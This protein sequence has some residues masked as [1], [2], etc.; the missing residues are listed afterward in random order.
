MECSDRRNESSSER[1]VDTQDHQ[2][3]RDDLVNRTKEFDEA[4]REQAEHAAALTVWIG[5]IV[6]ALDRGTATV[7]TSEFHHGR[8]DEAVGTLS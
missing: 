1:Y 5:S 4:D 8:V 3:A 7:Q 2:G 6:G